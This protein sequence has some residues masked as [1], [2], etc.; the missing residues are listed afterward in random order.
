M[1]KK[2]NITKD[3][4]IQEYTQNKKATKR[5]AIDFGCGSTTIKRYLKRYNILAIKRMKKEYFCKDCGVEISKKHRRCKPCSLKGE[6]NPFFGRCHTEKTKE[7]IRKNSSYLFGEDN[8]NCKYYL[9]K[10]FLIT[11]YIE[12]DKTTPQIAREIGCH[13]CTILRKIKFYNIPLKKHNVEK[14][15]LF[16]REKNPNWRNGLSKLPYTFYFTKELKEQIRKR[17][18]YTCQLCGITEEEHLILYGLVLSIHHID[19]DKPNCDDNNLITL[20][21]QC[22]ARVNFNRN[23]W[24]EHFT[25]LIGEIK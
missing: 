18:N 19:Y 11:E 9:G 5:I 16:I 4:L 8:P 24:Q 7:K 22:N 21:R 20:C 2:I 14:K 23:Y 17:D 3:F 15:K 1:S 13:S 12:K 6:N 25:K 10:G